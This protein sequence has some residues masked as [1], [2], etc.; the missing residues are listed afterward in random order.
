MNFKMS[1]LSEGDSLASPIIKEQN[2][3]ASF[4]TFSVHFKLHDPGEIAGSNSRS[5][6]SG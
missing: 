1:M 5:M 4:L 6:E 3:V 2:P